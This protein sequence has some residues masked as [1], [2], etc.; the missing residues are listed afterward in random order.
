MAPGANTGSVRDWVHDAKHYQF[1]N[2]GTED[3]KFTITNVR[4]G[5]YTLARVR[6]RRAGRICAGQH[7]RRGRQDAGS[8]QAGMEAAALWQTSLGDRLSQPRR[9]QI[10]QG[11]WRQLL[12]L[13]LGPALPAALSERH[14][15][16]HRQERLPQGL[17]L[18]AD[19]A[20]DV[21]GLDEPGGEGSRQPAISAG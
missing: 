9:R 4:P 11:G 19:A 2:D 12:A 7:H 13:G 10:L 17:V 21:D 8:E 16:H 1:W 18:S 5:K 6:R 14:H 15:L 3:G 20:R